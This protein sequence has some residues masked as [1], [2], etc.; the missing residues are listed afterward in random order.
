MGLMTPAFTE[1]E[2]AGWTCEMG[3]IQVGERQVEK[4]N[5]NKGTGMYVESELADWS[6]VEKVLLDIIEDTPVLMVWTLFVESEG[7]I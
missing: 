5:T 3:V 4:H 2:P 7:D 6:Q 1:K